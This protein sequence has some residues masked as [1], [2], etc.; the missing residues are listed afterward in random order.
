M[1]C[2]FVCVRLCNTTLYIE[3]VL[4]SVISIIVS[5]SSSSSSLPLNPSFACNILGLFTYL[6]VGTCVLHFEVDSHK[7]TNTHTL[8]IF[9]AQSS[10]I[11]ISCRNVHK[12]AKHDYCSGFKFSL[13]IYQRT[14]N[15]QKLEAR[16][17]FRH[18][19]VMLVV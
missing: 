12:L 10:K 15:G 2:V 1:R 3:K 5:S 11:Q 17:L 6:L 9:A 19:F 14:S 8:F 16:P 18:C 7:H 13:F 4:E